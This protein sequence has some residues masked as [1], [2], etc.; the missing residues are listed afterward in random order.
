MQPQGTNDRA[1]KRKIW[2][3]VFSVSLF[4]L[5]V[6]WSVDASVFHILAG[7]SAFSFYQFLQTRNPAK[8]RPQPGGTYSRASTP[9]FWEKVKALFNPPAHAQDPQRQSKLVFVIAVVSG[10][11]FVIILISAIFSDDSQAATTEARNR[12]N[13]FYS[14]GEYDSALFFYRLALQYEPDN[15]DLHLERGNAFLYANKPDSALIHYDKSLQLFPA[16]REAWYNKGLVYYNRQQ[17]PEAIRQIK[18][19]LRIDPEYTDAMLLTGDSFY[20]TNQMDSALKWYERAY[21][22]GYRSAALSHMLARLYDTRGDVQRA[23]GL[24]RE[25]LA[26]DYTRME[27]NQRLR[28]LGV[29]AE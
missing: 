25:A 15:A 12:A 19:A 10:F 22:L 23:I 2:L 20:S 24:Y 11:I 29:E 26:Y 16:Y 9:S 13:N 28:E 5:A 27:I 14:R 3:I 8:P 6:F 17:Y 18:E 4:L 21:S 7:F 1:G